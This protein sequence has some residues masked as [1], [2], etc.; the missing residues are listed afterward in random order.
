MIV[1]LQSSETRAACF[2]FTETSNSFT[3]HFRRLHFVFSFCHCVVILH[4]YRWWSHF[5]GSKHCELTE[6]ETAPSYWV[7]EKKKDRSEPSWVGKTIG[8]AT[9]LHVSVCVCIFLSIAVIVCLKWHDDCNA[10]TSESKS[11][12]NKAVKIHQA[13]HLSDCIVKLALFLAVHHNRIAIGKRY[14][15]DVMN[16]SR[17]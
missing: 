4:L 14:R 3:Q 7:R 2:Y 1:R 8:K 16:W 10:M 13:A 11:T 5:A 12:S 6:E 9:A 17:T 15:D